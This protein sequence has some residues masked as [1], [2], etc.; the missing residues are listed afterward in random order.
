MSVLD[1]RLRDALHHLS[2][3]GRLNVLI[4]LILRANVR[5]RCYPSMKLIAKE[6]GFGLATITEAKKWLEEHGAIEV[7]PY[8]QRVGDEKEKIKSTRQHVYQLTGVLKVDGVTYPYFYVSESE[9]SESEISVS[10][11]EV[12]KDSKKVQ[13]RK[14]IVAASDEDRARTADSVVSSSVEAEGDTRNATDTHPLPSAAAPS[15]SR[16]RS[17]AQLANDAMVD[18]LRWAWFEG[19]KLPIQDLGPTDYG[20]YLKRAKELRDGG[21]G[22]A[23]V[24]AYVEYWHAASVTGGWTLTLN[25]LVSNGRMAD[26]KAFKARGAQPVTAGAPAQTQAYDVRHDPAYAPLQGVKK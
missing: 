14:V 19:R 15:P 3:N 9:I 22:S 16:A 5:N 12:V 25:S 21:I 17:A 26:Y 2:T 6:T 23:D 11:T 7:V 1:W 20:L 8:A 13:K 4:A 10:E 24:K 18:T